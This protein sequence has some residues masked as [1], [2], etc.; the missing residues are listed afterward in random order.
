M[1]RGESHRATYRMHHFLSS[2][3]YETGSRGSLHALCL[4]SMPELIVCV[5]MKKLIKR[6]EEKR[7]P[8]FD[9]SAATALSGIGRLADTRLPM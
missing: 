9:Y 1:V 3:I 2:R 8:A 6:P 7:F 5:E 4:V